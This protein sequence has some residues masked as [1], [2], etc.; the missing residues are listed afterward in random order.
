MNACAV[1]A[2]ALTLVDE[3][4]KEGKPVPDAAV[5]ML[6]LVDVALWVKDQPAPIGCRDLERRYGV[7]RATAY[8]WL[9]AIRQHD[10]AH[11]VTV[12]PRGVRGATLRAAL[13]IQQKQ[14]TSAPHDEGAST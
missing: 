10:G 1:M 5:P 2:W 3:F 8:R 7:S 14:R 9:A 6:P 4:E 12:P 11:G 13:E